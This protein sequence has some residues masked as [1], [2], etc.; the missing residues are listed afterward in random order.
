MAS[1]TKSLS[2]SII[3]SPSLIYILLTVPGIKDD[4]NEGSAIC[5]TFLFSNFLVIIVLYLFSPILLFC[6]NNSNNKEHK[7]NNYLKKFDTVYSIKTDTFL[8]YKVYRS[9]NNT[10]FCDANLHKSKSTIN[11]SDFIINYNDLNY[12]NPYTILKSFSLPN[13][14]QTGNIT[15]Y[16]TL[17]NKTI[18]MTIENG[19]LHG[20]WEQY[21]SNGKL[22]IKGKY[23]GHARTGIWEWYYINGVLMKKGAFTPNV[24]IYSYKFTNDNFPCTKYGKYYKQ[25]RLMAKDSAVIEIL[26]TINKF[27]N[28]SLPYIINYRTGVWEIWDNNGIS[29]AKKTYNNEPCEID[30]SFDILQEFVKGDSK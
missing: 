24:I 23:E 22:M 21:Y 28:I 3:E 15:Y 4:T 27:S 13:Y 29:L 8:S 5:Q 19:Y 14:F 12:F 1:I 7:Q 11:Q 9:V 20:T 25:I 30:K 2:P 17:Q 18:K 10:L 6:Q 16:D 26:K